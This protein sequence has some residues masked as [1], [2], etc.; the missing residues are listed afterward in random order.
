[1]KGSYRGIE[2]YTPI[3]PKPRD[4]TTPTSTHSIPDTCRVPRGGAMIM[5]PLLQHASSRSSSGKR[6]RVIHIEFS[7][8]ELPVG[9]NWAERL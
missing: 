6:R 9:L 8:A 3:T 5:R 4:E 1:M 2:R 7:N